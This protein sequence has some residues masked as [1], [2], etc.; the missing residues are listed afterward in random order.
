VLIARIF[1]QALRVRVISK[2]EKLMARKVVNLTESA[3]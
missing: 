1:S 2:Y 3:K